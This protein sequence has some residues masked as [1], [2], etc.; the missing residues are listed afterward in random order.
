MSESLKTWRPLNEFDANDQRVNDSEAAHADLDEA[1]AGLLRHAGH[2]SE[3]A[4]DHEAASDEDSLDWA[5]DEA[6]AQEPLIRGDFAAIEAALLGAARPGALASGQSELQGAPSWARLDL[7]A[8][9]ADADAPP[10]GFPTLSLDSRNGEDTLQHPAPLLSAAVDS[11]FHPGVGV[12]SDNFMLF[13]D[14]AVSGSAALD[15]EDKR[16]RRPIYLMAALVLAGVAGMTATSFRHDGAGLSAPEASKPAV[17]SPFAAETASNAPTAPGAPDS[18]QQ[19]P[20]QQASATP[21]GAAPAAD[22]GPRVISFSEPAAPSEAAPAQ[23]ASTVAPPASSEAPT[24]QAVAT[25]PPVPPAPSEMA[26]ASILAPPPPGKAQM[27]AAPSVKAAIDEA[28]PVKTAAV[29]PDGSLVKAEP[30][31]TKVPPQE[32]LKK[33]LPAKAALVKDAA[34]KDAATKAAKTAHLRTPHPA[35]TATAAVAAVTSKSA[36]AAKPAPVTTAAVHAKP[37]TADTQAAAPAP[38]AQ[39]TA[40]AQAPAQTNG[41][42]AFV[43]TAVNSITGATGKLLDWGRTASSAH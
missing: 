16:S 42:L 6:P 8:S 20:V 29:R 39:P 7:R 21:D 4:A 32:A 14:A 11:A 17:M 37:A 35:T 34:A 5:A 38:A 41:A 9:R 3:S 22:A 12:P 15:E 28:R 30:P 19:A 2:P 18:A 43:D 10:S 27:L 23:S 33:E 24:A 13:D 36:V 40:A 26:T 31:A 25:L 1:L